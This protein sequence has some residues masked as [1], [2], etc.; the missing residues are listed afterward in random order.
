VGEEAK[1]G[2]SEKRGG[3]S[4]HEGRFLE[5]GDR[6]TPRM[7][8]PSLREAVADDPEV[9]GLDAA[10]EQL[11]L[12]ELEAEYPEVGHPAYPPKAMLKVLLYGYWLG[13]R[14][15]RMLERACKRDDALRFLAHGLR[16][17]HNSI[18]R[19]RR[20]HGEQL[21]ELFSQTVRLCQQAGLV[22]L[23]QV[24]VD[25]TKVRA[26]RSREGLAKAKREF[27]QALREAEEADGE[28]AGEREEC[29]FMKT[30]EGVLPA[31]N[32]QAAVDGD[33]QVIVAEDVG[34]VPNDTGHLSPMVEQTA[35]ACGN[36]PERVTADGSYYT[37]QG[38]REVEGMGTAV[39]LPTREPGQAKVEWVERKGAYR[40]LAGHW[41]RASRVERGRL[42]YQ[43]CGCGGCPKKKACGVRGKTKRVYVW[44]A[45]TPVGRVRA[46]MRTEE[47][48]AIHGARK[49]IVEPV[50]GRLKHNLGFRRLLLRGLS[51]ARIEWALV[52]MGHNLRKWVGAVRP[53][54]FAH[55]VPAS[56]LWWLRRV[57]GF[58]AGARSPGLRLD[59]AAHH[60]APILSPC[61][62]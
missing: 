39:Y 24:A 58:T 7:F 35:Q 4:T 34:R 17:D 23:G 22:E 41:L 2:L 61:A 56:I 44:L 46:R 37:R 15:S 40:C 43:W 55:S 29:E 11:E 20:R 28:E 42:V 19:F 49:Q 1:K 9:V 13:L 38:V 62:T 45:E 27:E 26:N 60:P 8:A 54:G 30:Q 10:V 47:G 52:C 25:G 57:G 59:P 21:G 50:F 18:C 53:Q 16:P 51:G 3:M 14:S 36:A 31:Y 5:L 6:E 12:R 48:R 32:A 33:H